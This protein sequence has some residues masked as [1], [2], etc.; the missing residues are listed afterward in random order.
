MMAMPRLSVRSMAAAL[1]LPLGTYSNYES[2]RY[3]KATLPLDLTR[4]IAAV[5][6]RHSVD[7]AEVMKLAGLA[8][9]ETEPEVRNIQDAQPQLQFVT[10][11]M[12]MPS[13]E[14]LADM[15]QSLLALVPVDATRAEAARI[16][17]QR[18]PAGFAAIGPVVP[19][20]GKVPM[21]A[22]AEAARSLATDRP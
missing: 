14:A 2:S 5:L 3:K 9:D 4:R 12:V 1:D 17:A 13:E 8:E 10:C 18:L 15:F 6:A 7:P 20:Q 22:P 16:L 11:T 19:D 21:I